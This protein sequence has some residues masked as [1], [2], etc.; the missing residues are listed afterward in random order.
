MIASQY[1]GRQDE[2][3]AR[4][5]AAQLYCVLGISTVSMWLFRV[6]LSYI[7]V[8]KLHMGLTGVWFGMFIDWICRGICFWARFLGGKRMEHKVI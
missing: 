4:H 2:E 6:M 1:M 3:N 5:S 8:L 7:F